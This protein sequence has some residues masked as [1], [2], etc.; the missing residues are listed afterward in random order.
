MHPFIDDGKFVF[1]FKPFDILGF[2]DNKDKINIEII[3]AGS[4][5]ITNSLSFFKGQ[6][7]ISYA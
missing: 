7:D 6:K 5:K 4:N 3:D 2:D 1:R